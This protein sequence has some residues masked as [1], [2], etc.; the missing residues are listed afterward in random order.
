MDRY[1]GRIS[2]RIPSAEAS[3]PLELGCL[4]LPHF[5]YVGVPTDLEV[6]ATGTLWRLLHMGMINL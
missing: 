1:T 4:T 3:V 6:H 5:P 2:G